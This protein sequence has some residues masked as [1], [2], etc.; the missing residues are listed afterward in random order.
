MPP[1]TPN[2]I[3]LINKDDARRGVFTL[4]EH[5]AHARCADADKHLNKVRAADRKEWNIRFT[6]N[7]ACEKRFTSARRPDHQDALG[8][9]STQFLK[10]FRV[11]QKLDELQHFILSF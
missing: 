7:S 6:R 10:F 9:A 3:D 8:N 5:V 4:I 2:G 11:T 1:M